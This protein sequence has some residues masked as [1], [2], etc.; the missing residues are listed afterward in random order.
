MEKADN[1]CVRFTGKNYTAWEFQLETFLKGKALWGHIDGSSKGGSSEADKAAWAAKDNQIMSWILGSM[2]PHLILSLRPH[3]SAKAMW[4]YLKQV[5]HQDN[6]ARRFHLELAIANY[7][8]RGFITKVSA[9]GLASVQHVHR[10]SQRD[11]FLMKLRPEFE[12]IR[13]SLVNRD[14]VPTLEACFGELLREE[15]RLNTQNLMEQSRIASNTVS[16]AYAAHGKGK[17]RDMST[18]QCYSCKKYGHIAPNCPQKFCNYCKQPGH[19]IKECTIRPSRSTKAYH[20][21]VTDDSQ[22]AANA[23]SSAVVLQPPAPSLTR[24]MVQ[25]MIVS[26]F[27]ALGFQG[28]GSSPS[29]ILDSGASNHMTNS[30]HGLSNVR[31]YCGSSHIQTANVS[32][33]QLVD[34]DYGVNFTHDG[35]V[36]QDQM[37]GQV[38]AKGPKHGRLFS[39][40]I[41]APRNLPPFL[42]LLCNK[43]RVSPEVWHKRLGHPNS[44]ILSYLLKS[45]LLNNK[46]HFSSA[47]FSDCATCKLGKSKI[48]PFPS[49]GSRATHSFEIIHSDVW[50]ISPTISHAQYK[51]FVTFIDDYSKYT[52]VYFLRHK[53]EVFPMF[54]LFLALVQTQFSA[55]VKILRSDSGGEYMSHEFQSFLHS[56]GIISQRSCPYTPQQNGVAERKNRHLLD[57][58]RTLLIESSVP[59]KFWVEALTTA[60]FLINRLPSQALNLES[61]YFRLYHHHPTYTNLH[62]FGCV[63]FMHL[64]PPDRNKLSAQSIRCAFLG[65]SV[66]QKGYVCYDPTSNRVRVSRNVL[67]FENQWFFPMSSSSESPV[68]FL[69]SF[70]DTLHDPRPLIERFQPGMVYQRRSPVLPPSAPI[71]PPVP[72]RRSS[73]VSAPPDR[74]GFPLTGTTS[75]ALSATLSSIAVPTSYSQAVKEKCWQQAMQEELCALEANKTWDVIDCPAGVTPLG[76]KWVYS[77]KVKSDGSLDR[78]KARLVALGNNQEYGVNYEETFAP[79]AKMTTIRTILAIAASQNWDLHQMDVKNAFLHGDL[80]EDVYM[81]PPAG[82]L[83]TPTSAVCKLRRS[84]YGLKQA[85]R[86]WYEK[87]TSTLFK[88]ALHKSKYDA[89][90]FLRKTENGVVI[91]L[92]YVDDIIITGTDSA[93]IS[94]LKQYLQDSFHMKDLGSLTYFLGLEIT[95]GA[96]GIFLSQHKYAQDLVAAAGLQDST[97]LD[98]PMELNLKLRKEE[99]DLLSDPVSYRTL[100]GSLVYLTITRPD[101]SYAVQQVS[102]FMASPRHLHMAAVR[103]IIRY[104]HGTALRGLSYPAGTSLDLAA[105][106]DADYAGCSDTRRST[107]GWC[108]F[109]GPALI[110]WKSKKQDRVSKSSTESEYRAMSQACAEIL[111]LRGLLTELGFSPRGPTSL[112]ADNTSAIHI[113]ANPIFHER[114]K[115]IKVDCHFIREAFEAQTISLPHVPTNLQVADIFTKALTRQRHNF[116]TNKLM[117][118]DNPHQFEGGCQ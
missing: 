48:L 82:L 50:G 76:C 15:Q 95:T 33:G 70:D 58:V 84:L 99:G 112:H 85:P 18:T 9:E 88:F 62:T 103:R 32:V 14:P 83:S 111:W 110:S 79:V 92:V 80:K 41:P 64:P 39:L 11:Q 1:V 81:R 37:S 109:L 97:P 67:F 6:N 13:A 86:A 16:V 26:A 116:L 117:L 52:W 19:I 89:S 106:S 45:G 25:E 66:T 68:A 21:V 47:V 78:Y 22:P 71:L 104:V 94:Q 7:T 118:V 63:C 27:S 54:K 2:E 73:R 10:T 90:L 5:Y 115:H 38:I 114:T 60:T 57:V 23:V 4:D 61:P 43:S 102:Q 105:Y 34:Q 36:V 56:K 108:M 55:T 28:T 20:A 100:V 69:P 101:I 35:C 30:L 107:T 72:L 17:G 51:Y 29:W 31:E 96:H 53:S 93:L 3:R 44:R 24:E 74:Y 40:Q 91:L 98:T 12:S 77:I 42:S 113:S 8:S 87:F 46:E 65:Y 75:S 59:P 49:E